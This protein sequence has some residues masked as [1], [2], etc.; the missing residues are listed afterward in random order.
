MQVVWRQGSTRRCWP[1][2]P[3]S[4]RRRCA[5]TPATAATSGTSW[6][7]TSGYFVPS[8]ILLLNCDVGG[9]V[10]SDLED[11]FGSSDSGAGGAHRAD[12]GH[13]CHA[14]RSGS[15]DSSARQSGTPSPLRPDSPL[16]SVRRCPRSKGDQGRTRALARGSFRTPSPD[17]VYGVEIPLPVCRSR[18]PRLVAWYF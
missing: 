7:A 8:F 12:E 15:S 3:R 4:S 14:A 18:A 6:A 17:P 11:G 10:L 9:D 13:P 1:G 16:A 2:S 5:R